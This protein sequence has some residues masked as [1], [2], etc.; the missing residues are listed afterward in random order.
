M[1]KQPDSP[2]IAIAKCDQIIRIGEEAQ[3]R[4][5]RP[6]KEPE[7]EP[8]ASAADIG[9]MIAFTIGGVTLVGTVAGAV[10][11]IFTR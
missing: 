2:E 6:I 1:R 11:Y 5:A 3:R 10:W 8:A 4:I 9:C 7:S